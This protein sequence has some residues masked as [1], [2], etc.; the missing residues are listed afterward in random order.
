MANYIF[1]SSPTSVLLDVDGRQTSF[2]SKDLHPYTPDRIG[3]VVYLYDD[4]GILKKN[5]TTQ[6][7]GDRIPIDITSD[8]IDVDGTTVWA[9]AG[10]LFDALGAIFFLASGGGGVQSVTGDGV[11]G[12]A[13]DVVLTFPMPAEIG[14]ERLSLN[15]VEVFQ[16]SDL[17]ATLAVDTKYVIK[18]PIVLTY[19]LTQQ[20]GSTNEIFT[21][22]SGVNTITFN[23]SDT[24]LTGTGVKSLIFDRITIA[25]NGTGELFDLIGNGVDAILQLYSL[26]SFSGFLSLGSL[27]SYLII[28]SDTNE[29]ADFGIGLSITNTLIISIRGNSFNN[30]VDSGNIF[31]NVNSTASP[32]LIDVRNNALFT[33]PN[34]AGI[35]IN[36]TS[37]PFLI[38]GTVFENSGLLSGEL[39]FIDNIGSITAYA[40]AGGGQVTVSTSDT[41]GLI[42]GDSIEISKTINYNGGYMIS[43]IVLNTSFEITAPFVGDDGV[44]EWSDGSV[45]ETN[46]RVIAKANASQKD[47]NFIGSYLISNNATTTVIPVSNVWQ[48]FDFGTGVITATNNERYVVTD[49]VNGEIRYNGL[50]GFN[51]E[52]TCVFSAQSTGG[53]IDYRFRIV[54]NSGG[55]YTPLPDDVEFINTFGADTQMVFMSLPISINPGDLLKPEL[56]RESGV[57]NLTTISLSFSIR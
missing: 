7:S 45:R 38:A 24:F 56:L 49:P 5:G 17:P 31:I 35:Y 41:T 15:V 16:E 36:P 57:S 33:N 4:T 18:A 26:C 42:N 14:A 12:T 54:C 52:L 19:G 11:G 23:S 50:S 47:S 39:F 13:E 30:S 34:E 25:N 20:A 55:G 37:L 1:T 3:N 51:G 44:G 27:S 6:G 21:T 8:T 40:D 32:Y 2:G 46:P 10:A 43:N 29:I 9:D 48:D 28:L 53:G 22:L